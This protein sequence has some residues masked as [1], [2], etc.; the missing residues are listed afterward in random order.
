MVRKDKK[1]YLFEL[2]VD[3]NDV[4]IKGS[5]NDWKEER[6]KKNKKGVFIK[7]K[8][9]NPGVYE[10]GYLVDGKW[11]A[12]ESCELVDSPFFSKNSLL[13]VKK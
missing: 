10:F 8:K 6:M 3:A 4:F 11:I 2:K 9:L 12:D 1:M 13:K 7:R 5:W